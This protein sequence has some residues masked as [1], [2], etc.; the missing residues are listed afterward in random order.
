MGVS[1]QIQGCTWGEGGTSVA[2]APRQQSPRCSKIN[3]GN[4]E[5]CYLH[6]KMFN[7]CNKNK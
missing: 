6:S 7:F 1:G 4:A 2:A 3:I 5:V